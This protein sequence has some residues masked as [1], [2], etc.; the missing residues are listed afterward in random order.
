MSEPHVED[1]VIHRYRQLRWETF[2]PK[3]KAWLQTLILLPFG[4]PVGHF[5]A[6]SWQFAINSIFEERQYLIGILSMVFNLLLPSLFFAFVFHWGWFGWRSTAARWYPQ[7]Q[8]FWAGCYATLTIALA[9]GTVG[10]FTSSLGVCG[11]PAWNEI[12]QS[13]L[14]N[15]DGYGF[16]SKSWFGVWFIIAAYCYQ[17]RDTLV[18]RANSLQQKMFRHRYPQPTDRSDLSSIVTGD[19]D[20]DPHEDLRATTGEPMTAKLQD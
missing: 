2:L 10:L 19:S 9:F 13:L 15:L 20:L 12:G 4:L 6:A 17:V 7:T 5:L 3:R 11:N 16:E 18:A 14:C 1:L 8:A